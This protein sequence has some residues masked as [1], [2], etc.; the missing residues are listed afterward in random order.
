MLRALHMPGFHRVFS[1]VPGARFVFRSML[2][3]ILTVCSVFGDVVPAPAAPDQLPP[4]STTRRDSA[5]DGGDG[6]QKVRF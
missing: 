2:T 5:M 1:T 6:F 3:G 4:T